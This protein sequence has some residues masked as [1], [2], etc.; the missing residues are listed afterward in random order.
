MAGHEVH[1]RLRPVYHRLDRI[2]VHVMLCRLRSRLLTVHNLCLPQVTS[3]GTRAR[4]Y[5]RISQSFVANSAEG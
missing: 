4:A 3:C 1:L 2:R 5:A